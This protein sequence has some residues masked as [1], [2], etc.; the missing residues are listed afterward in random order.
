MLLAIQVVLLLVTAFT[1]A[2]M[3]LIIFLIG[4]RAWRYLRGRNRPIP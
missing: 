4:R 1:V 2:M 3:A